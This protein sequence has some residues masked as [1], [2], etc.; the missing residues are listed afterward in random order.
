MAEPTL[1]FENMITNEKHCRPR[2]CLTGDRLYA[3]QLSSILVVA[4]S[5]LCCKKNSTLP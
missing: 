2:F 4:T 5:C 3:A 1:A